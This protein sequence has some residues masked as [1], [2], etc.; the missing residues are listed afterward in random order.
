MSATV[1]ENPLRAGMR[2]ERTSEPCALVIF[3][4]T[5]DLTRRKLIP[6]LFQL[7]QQRMIPAEFA[8]LGVGPQQFSDE[9]CR[10]KMREAQ[11]EFGDKEEFDE[12]S[13]ESF[14]QGL[15]Y[16]SGDFSSD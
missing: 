10:S 9:E 5:G 8:V 1:A 11:L 2:I 4:A 3:G 6:A 15:F 16:T 14:S 13:W 12:S 7:A